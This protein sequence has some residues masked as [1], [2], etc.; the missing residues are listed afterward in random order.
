MPALRFTRSPA[1]AEAAASASVQGD[2]TEP[3]P[4]P[5]ALGLTYRSIHATPIHS[6]VAAR[7]EG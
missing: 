2:P 7:P 1:T 5:E 4:P 6:V 3:S